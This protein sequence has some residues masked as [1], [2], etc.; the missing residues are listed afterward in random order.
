MT[1][2][3][4]RI[5][6][7]ALALS[8]SSCLFPEEDP[9]QASTTSSPPGDTVLETDTEAGGET[10]PV[11]L[12]AGEGMALEGE[13][14]TANSDCV[15]GV[16]TI[17]TDAPHNAD[18]T[19]GPTPDS[20]STRVTGTIL[21]F[22]TGTP[23]DGADLVVAAAL[24]ATTSPTGATAIVSATSGSD[25]RVD[26]TS[27]APIMAPLGIVGLA[28]ADGYYLTAT[29]LAV[30]VEGTSYEVGTRNHDIWAVP[31]SD[32]TDWSDSLSM[33]PE[34]GGDLLPLGE[35]GG[36]VGLIRDS[37][38]A[39]LPGAVV[40]SAVDGST[41]VVRYLNDDGTFNSTGTAS[42]GI[43]VIIDPFVP[44]DFEAS[45]DGTVVGG[46]TASSAAGALFTLIITT[47]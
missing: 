21:D 14:C 29:E 42:S 18:A 25:G 10:G 37:T 8:P 36:A 20:C 31:S 44:E 43:F 1:T 6:A 19:C 24:Q 12:G 38:G 33:D 27:D 46:G 47:S 34:V 13:G 40:T 26:A 41:A 3:R 15:S 35:A 32:L 28:L 23:I 45:I 30:P 2:T 7:L 5:L 11:C 16:C 17:Y 4:S 22:S 39:A 9:E